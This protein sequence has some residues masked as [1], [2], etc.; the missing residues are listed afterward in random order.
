MV[1]Q[2]LTLTSLLMVL[3]LA[4]C[5]A[6]NGVTSFGSDTLPFSDDYKSGS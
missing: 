1:V 4:L 6:Q 5:F 2:R 3:L